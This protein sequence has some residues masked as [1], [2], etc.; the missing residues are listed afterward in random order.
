MK[1]LDFKIRTWRKL[2]YQFLIEPSLKEKEMHITYRGSRIKVNS[3]SF[4][5]INRE[6]GN[7]SYKMI[8]FSRFKH[9]GFA[10]HICVYQ[11]HATIYI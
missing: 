1:S 3:I 9:T 6:T 2:N 10:I 11:N 7:K 5:D 8:T 4:Y